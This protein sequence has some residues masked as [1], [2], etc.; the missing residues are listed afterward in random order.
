MNL[1]DRLK[2]TYGK[3]EFA[4]MTE[5]F[6]KNF[7]QQQRNKVKLQKFRGMLPI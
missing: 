4:D 7:L 6:K 1:K 5:L 2:C 3:L